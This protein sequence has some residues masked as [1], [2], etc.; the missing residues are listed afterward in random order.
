MGVEVVVVVVACG[1]RQICRRLRQAD[2]VRRRTPRGRRCGLG[3]IVVIVLA[4]YHV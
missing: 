1:R 4:R 3:D 2:Q